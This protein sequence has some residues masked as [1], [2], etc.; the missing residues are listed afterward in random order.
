VMDRRSAVFSLESDGLGLA[1]RICH[2]RPNYTFVDTILRPY[3]M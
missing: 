1:S 3:S 2:F